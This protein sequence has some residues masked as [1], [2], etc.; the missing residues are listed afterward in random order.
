MSIK[1]DLLYIAAGLFS[2]DETAEL[3]EEAK[4][5]ISPFR[6]VMMASQIKSNGG[7]E[8]AGD[9]NHGACQAV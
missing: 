8:H 3:T 1:K 4:S 7:I 5:H 9:Q 2:T 6:F